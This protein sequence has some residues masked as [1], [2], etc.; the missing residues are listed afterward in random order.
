MP[1]FGDELPG[2]L[3]EPVQAALLWAQAAA[4]VG[5]RSA[6]T[7]PIGSLDLLTGVLLA[8]LHNSPA[9]V[10]FEHFGISPGEVLSPGS[11]GLLTAAALRAVAARPRP[12]GVQ[13]TEEARRIFGTLKG[14]AGSE[15]ASLAQLLG[16]TLL[17]DTLAGGA[18]HRA[19]AARGSGMRDV[20]DAYEAYLHQSTRTLGDFLK[21]RFPYQPPKVTLADYLTD[22]PDGTPDLI[23][24]GP[25]VNAFAHLIT[26]KRLVPPLAIGLFGDWGSGKSYFVRSLRQRVSWIAEAAQPDFHKSVVQVEFNA[27]QYVGG[28]LWASLVEHLFRNL[29]ISGDDSDDLIAQRQKYWLQQVQAAGAAQQTA[30]VSREALET[31]R[32]NAAKEVEERT[33]ELE[34]AAGKLAEAQRPKPSAA[35]RRAVQEAAATAGFTEVIDN[36]VKLREELDQAGADL[37]SLLTPLRNWK[38]WLFA[39]IALFAAPVIA[40]VMRQFDLA[41]VSTVAWLLGTAASY[42][43]LAGKYLQAARKKI[44]DAQ[45]ELAAAEQE[46]HDRIEREVAEAEA[47]LGAIQSEL[48]GA[49]QRERD[50]AAKFDEVRREQEAATPGQVLD[51]FITERLGSDDYRRHLG[52]PALVRRDLERLSRLVAAQDSEAPGEYAIDRIVL[53]IDDLDRCPTPMVIK[54]LEAVHLLLAFPVF[55]VVVAVD[56]RW[57]TSSLRQH[58]PQLA[59]PDADPED[60]LE[61]IFQIPFRIQPLPVPV[62]EQ[63]TR[64]LLAPSTI[65]A[66]DTA[67]ATA[68]GAVYVPWGDLDEFNEVVASF[69]QVS[70]GQARPVAVDLTITQ[71]E[72]R[73]AEDVAELIGRTPRA[74]KRFVNVYLLIKAI[75]I[76]RDWEVPRRGQLAVLVA[77]A[78]GLPRTAGPLFAAIRSGSRKLSD[79]LPAP[80]EEDVLHNWVALGPGRDFSLDGL[81]GW[82][83]L[84]G[85]FRHSG[86]VPGRMDL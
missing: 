62:R 66:P 85:R 43:A 13:L 46:E 51:E 65:V 67:A 72:L 42:V 60:Y 16:A 20:G 86:P 23:G 52:V 76:G 78:V 29:R 28:D 69:S 15:P 26:S 77:V 31:K 27:G 17:S 57:L 5:A 63:M 8:D 37:R 80:S 81:T 11:R 68:D 1:E 73:Q 33:R 30:Q 21:Q 79:A 64:G 45:A 7:A 41:A 3:S 53:Y 71:E 56:A 61:K 9:R 47:M 4:W 74:V 84:I 18:L 55:V 6:A 58:Y 19:L 44:A 59:G 48:D 25:E 75:G 70:G 36:A 82:V 35:L 22:Q 38:Y 40:V 83:D 32:E 12:G 34:Q 54:V 2:S 39:I 50:L 10:L 14:Y 24:I 49:V